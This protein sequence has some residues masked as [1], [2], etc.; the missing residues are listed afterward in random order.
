MLL[1]SIR[2][3]TSYIWL[4]CRDTR[5]KPYAMSIKRARH[6]RAL[7]FIYL[8]INLIDDVLRGIHGFAVEAVSDESADEDAYNNRQRHYH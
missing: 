2:Y 6:W 5:F 8:F 3:K 4:L 7:F 1:K